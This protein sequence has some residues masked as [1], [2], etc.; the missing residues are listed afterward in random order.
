[1]PPHTSL[2]LDIDDHTALYILET[3]RS[4]D[5][6]RDV[7][8]QLAGLLVLAATGAKSAGP[9]HPV[10]DAARQTLS[11]ASDHV[12]RVRPTDRARIH[13]RHLLAAL[14]S[15]Q[16]A[17]NAARVRPAAEDIDSTLLPL[18]LAYSHL[19]AAAGRLPGFDLVA[20][21]MGCCAVGR[22]RPARP[23]SPVTSR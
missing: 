6:L 1:M 7:A 11:E 15:L 10:L 4:F 2:P 17:M 19:Q 13:H 22:I 20:L 14:V 21:A 3:Q 5:A 16:T 8:S 23:S 9:H 18:R 12:R